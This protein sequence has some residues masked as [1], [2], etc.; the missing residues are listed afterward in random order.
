MSEN[1]D[2]VLQLVRQIQ[3]GVDREESFRELF[4]RFWWPI[5][6]YFRRK[7]FS[8]EQSYDL[9]QESFLQILKSL[10]TFRGDSRLPT[11]VF[12]VVSNVYR[13]ELRRRSAERRDSV[14]LSID[15]LPDKGSGANLQL[16]WREPSALEVAIGREQS[17]DLRAALRDL[18]PQMRYCSV[19]RYERELSYQ[20]IATVMRISIETVKA[21]L[22]QARKR[23]TAK[24]GETDLS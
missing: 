12:G 7:G 16:P 13:N 9:R 2:P 24:L 1:P 10:D 11:W 21:H 22:H 8:D 20:E 4:G 5:F 19:L 3:A 18:P 17:A 6:H 14:E 15:T 23:L